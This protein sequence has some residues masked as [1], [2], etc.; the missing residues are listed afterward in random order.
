[1]AQNRDKQGRDKR[2]GLVS[3]LLGW[4]TEPNESH[5][6]A[7]PEGSK[8]SHGPGPPRASPWPHLEHHPDLAGAEVDHASYDPYELYAGLDP[9]TG[10]EVRTHP[11]SGLL[12]VGPPGSNK[13]AGIIVQ[14]ILIFLGLVVA[15]SSRSDVYMV[16]ALFR[17]RFGTVWSL[18]NRKLP[19]AT[20]VRFSPLQGCGESWSYTYKTAHRWASYKD[21]S[22]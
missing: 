14:N 19:G 16:T 12:L 22:A 9:E 17:A 6:P 11:D 2:S 21:M 20:E 4:L 18:L 15:V 1:M 5:G 8:R 10:E 3:S 7:P 13:T